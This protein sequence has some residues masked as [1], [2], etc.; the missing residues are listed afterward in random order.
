M[1]L[2]TISDPLIG[3]FV[4]DYA[5]MV[6]ASLDLYETCHDESWLR[7]A[8]S[9]QQVQDTLFWDDAH[10]AYFSTTS[11]DASIILRL[12][13]G[14]LRSINDGNSSANS[15]LSKPITVSAVVRARG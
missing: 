2:F 8:V 9:L 4:D 10:S 7:F 5:M 15:E 12:K 6:R 3:G 11:D 13:D 14:R 1:G